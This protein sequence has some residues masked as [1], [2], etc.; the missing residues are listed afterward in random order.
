MLELLKSE[1]KYRV[2]ATKEAKILTHVRDFS[3][4]DFL[5]AKYGALKNH[6]IEYFQEMLN[7]KKEFLLQEL[8]FRRHGPKNNVICFSKF[9]QPPSQKSVDAMFAAKI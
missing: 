3:M 5:T 2:S 8:I 1:T 4:N 9:S 6:L 7:H